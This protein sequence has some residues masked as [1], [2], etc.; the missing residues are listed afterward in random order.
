MSIV[1]IELFAS[2][3]AFEPR[4]RRRMRSRNHLLRVSYWGK[5]KQAAALFRD[6]VYASLRKGAAAAV[7]IAIPAMVVQALMLAL[8]LSYFF[9]PAS[10]VVFKA[11]VTVRNDMGL[12]FSFLSLGAIAIL[13]E[14]LRPRGG[15]GK[16]TS[17]WI[18]A[19]YAFFVMGF[20]G[21]FTDLFY[22]LQDSMW[23]RLSPTAKIVAKVM[24]DQFVYTVLFANPYQT[25]LYVFKDC[26]FESRSFF[27]RITPFKNFYVREMLAVLI[28]NWAFWIPTTAI[29]YSLP[30]DLQF[31]MSRLAVTIW[32]LLLTTITKRNS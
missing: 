30:L 20:L 19:G 2:E 3:P 25:F 9:V 31:I 15:D 26:S 7:Q 22:M 24:T 8:A 12:C 17:F 27:E 6:V 28:T 21:I 14:S 16:K 5:A 4:L 29:L 1:K 18:S 23:S 32:V 10:L 13:A 11:I